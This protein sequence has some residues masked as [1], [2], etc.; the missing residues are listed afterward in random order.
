MFNN[1]TRVLNSCIFIELRANN[2]Y[3]MQ[4]V[5]IL[6]EFRN[7]NYNCKIFNRLSKNN[8]KIIIIINYTINLT[9]PI[10]GFDRTHMMPDAEL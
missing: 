1:R 7:G 3:M 8:S 5:C 4:L 10:A 6:T 2:G 9:S